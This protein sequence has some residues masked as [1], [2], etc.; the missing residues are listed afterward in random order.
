MIASAAPVALS[1]VA[2]SCAKKSRVFELLDKLEKKG[3]PTD[4]ILNGK[5]RKQLEKELKNNK[6]AEKQLIAALESAL[7]TAEE[8]EK[9]GRGTSR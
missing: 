8:L 2:I 7:K 9:L 5:N 1:M 6:E 4:A 3:I